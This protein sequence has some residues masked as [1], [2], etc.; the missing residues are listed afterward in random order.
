MVKAVFFTGYVRK[1]L[2]CDYATGD[3]FSR[4]SEVVEM[5]AFPL[6]RG[7]MQG[8]ALAWLSHSRQ[9]WRGRGNY[10]KGAGIF[11]GL[12]GVRGLP[13]VILREMGESSNGEGSRGRV[14]L[15]CGK[16]RATRRWLGFRCAMSERRGASGAALSKC[17]RRIG[18]IWP[19]FELVRATSGDW[20]F[21]RPPSSLQHASA[22]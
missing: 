15:H 19:Q 16:V 10:W 13:D 11:R 9:G 18:R 14:G 5:R 2:T 21:R 17:E 6:L 7:R 22:V 4:I 12:A 8:A 1:R 3:F 20:G